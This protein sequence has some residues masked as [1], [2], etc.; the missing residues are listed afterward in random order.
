MTITFDN[1]STERAIKMRKKQHLAVFELVLAS[2]SSPSF[3]VFLHHNLV[4][5]LHPPPTLA[6]IGLVLKVLAFPA[7]LF[8][9]LLNHY[10]LPS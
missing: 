2:W 1:F 4:A 9:P 3:F 10:L 7:S 8:G 5:H 6:Q